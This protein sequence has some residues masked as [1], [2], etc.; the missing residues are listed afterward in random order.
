MLTKYAQAK[1]LFKMC[2]PSVE[3][4]G[5]QLHFQMVAILSS[6]RSTPTQINEIP[7]PL[8]RAAAR[9]LKSAEV[10]YKID[11]VYS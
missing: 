9:G 11:T 8:V 10:G 7:K 3:K 4:S 1:S 2:Q 6:L 5:S